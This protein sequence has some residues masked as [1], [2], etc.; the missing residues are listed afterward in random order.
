MYRTIKQAEKIFDIFNEEFYDGEL[1][2]P[3]FT[4]EEN[5]KM[6]HCMSYLSQ[7]PWWEDRKNGELKYQLTIRS[8]YVTDNK[9]V[10]GEMILHEMA[11]LY[12]VI[13]NGAYSDTNKT[14]KKHNKLFK[15]T[16]ESHGLNVSPEDPKLGFAFVELGDRARE[17]I[18]ST[19]FYDGFGMFE[20]SQPIEEEKE[21]N[22]KTKYKFTCG[23]DNKFTITT[24][25]QE[26]KCSCGSIMTKEVVEPEEM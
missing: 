21:K 18:D 4:I 26:V 15:D 8:R 19:E 24:D 13:Y 23:C 22:I 3:I 9:E 6:A 25:V 10:F 2:K 5:V 17:I 7:D 11:H 20:L 16:A 14:G 1:D 12:N